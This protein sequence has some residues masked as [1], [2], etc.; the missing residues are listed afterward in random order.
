[1]LLQLKDVNVYYDKVQVLKNICLEVES[2]SAVALV[3]ANGA[4]KT[5]T[6]RTVSGLKRTSSG[7]ISFADER[8][9]RLA[10]DEIVRRGIVHVAE[11][12][13]LFP[14]ISVLD[15]IKMGAYLQNNSRVKDRLNDIYQRFPILK[16]RASQLAVTL[17]GGEKQ[18]LAVARALMA[19]PRLLL[20]DEPTL[21]LSPVMA[22]QIARIIS[23]INHDGISVVLVEQNARVALTLAQTGYVME[24]GRIV[25]K[26][27]GEQLLNDSNVK[28]A[29]LGG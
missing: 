14:Y 21:G 7:E 8:I 3:G 10:V 27:T 16:Q 18:M 5:T 6:L 25:L 4:G 26:G 23:E 2:G 9:D 17:S 11:G 1:M 24:T 15:N 13:N 19:N 12:G 29:Y 22:R 28:E 20:L